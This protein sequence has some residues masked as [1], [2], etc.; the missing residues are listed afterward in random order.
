MSFGSI[1]AN[2]SS[3]S[4]A[5][6]RLKFLDERLRLRG[7]VQPPGTPISRIARALDQTRFLEPV[8]DPAQG[9]RLDIEHVGELDLP[10]AGLPRQPEQHLPLRAR[11]AEPD[12]Q[13]V[14]RL[15]QRM[16]GLTD[17]EREAFPS[18]TDIVSL[19]ILSNAES[20]RAFRRIEDL[21]MVES[22][23]TVM[24]LARLERVTGIEPVRSAWEADRLPLHHTR[25]Q[26]LSV[27]FRADPRQRATNA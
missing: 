2:A 9:D 21:T 26:L 7:D 17:F 5:A 15:A 22:D 8:D 14:E 13:A 25:E 18:A 11:H 27:R 6:T 23:L 19:L 1:P 3:T 20:S 4:S 12:R 10:K 24:R 16:R